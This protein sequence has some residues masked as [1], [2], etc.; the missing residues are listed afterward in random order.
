MDN[1]NTLDMSPGIQR[2]NRISTSNLYAVSLWHSVG[3]GVKKI[4]SIAL[5]IQE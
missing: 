1:S 3:D 5:W 2:G 4:R